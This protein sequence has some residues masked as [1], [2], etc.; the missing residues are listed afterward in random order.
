MVE[1]AALSQAARSAGFE[2]VGVAP[3]E[4]DGTGWFAPHAEHLKDW[5]EAG[6]HAEMDYLAERVE[7]RVV[8][9]RLL[10]GVRSAVVLWLPHR[11]PDLPRPPGAVGRVAT[12]AW[13]RDYHNVARKGLR[14]LRKWLQRNSPGVGTYLS[15]DTAPVLE[16]AFGERAGVGWIGRSMMLIHPR[17]GTFGSLAVLFVDIELE[18]APEAHAFRCG[19]CTDC[20]DACPTGAIT[21]AGVDARLCISYW[22]IEHAGSIP[23]AIRPLLGDWVFGCDICQDVCPWNHDAPRADPE[24]WRPVPER[25]WADLAQWALEPP[26]LSGSPMQRAGAASLR[27]NALIALANGGYVEALPTVDLVATGDTDPILRETASWAARVL[28]AV[29][30]AEPLR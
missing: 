1:T 14:K 8:P 27:R 22:T 12:Y 7:E 26:D 19:T 11:V 24:R 2:L 15:V 5:L 10:P 6:A 29:A 30:A 28:R 3:V 20:V 13:G 25:A 9:E 18:F 17:L 16:R 21:D 23:E 4:A